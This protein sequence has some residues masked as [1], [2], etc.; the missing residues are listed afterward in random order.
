LE[1]LTEG[2]LCIRDGWTEKEGAP[3]RHHEGNLGYGLDRRLMSESLVCP[4]DYRI[5]TLDAARRLMPVTASV[6]KG[7]T[8]VKAEGHQQIGA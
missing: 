7:E 6:R 5:E 4:P 3:N 1:Q 2:P 8:S